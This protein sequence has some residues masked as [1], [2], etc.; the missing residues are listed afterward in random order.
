MKP[1]YAA[2]IRERVRTRV[3]IDAN[4]CWVFQ[5]SILPTG[6]GQLWDGEHRGA[7][8]HRTSYRAFVGEIPDG[9]VIDHLCRNR[10]C[11][12]PDHL[13]PVTCREN[14]LRGVGP[15]AI[16]ARKTECK[17]GHQYT[18]GNT[19]MDPSRGL[20]ECRACRAMRRK[21]PTGAVR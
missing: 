7:R 15:T 10:A 8:A 16:N 4:G 1:E 14:I 2:T 6:Y 13:E 20:R 18:P 11:L 19:Y 3:I 21:Q 12:N 5:G 9:L 17:R